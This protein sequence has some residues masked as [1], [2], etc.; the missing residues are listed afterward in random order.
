MRKTGE[1]KVDTLDQIHGK[2][3]H[4]GEM[5]DTKETK[6]QRISQGSPNLCQV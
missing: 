4:L 2:I 5:E 1:M 6:D 3:S